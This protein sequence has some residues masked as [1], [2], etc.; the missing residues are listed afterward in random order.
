[1]P[2]STS[3]HFC[4]CV[5]SR[6]SSMSKRCFTIHS[7]GVLD[8][9][10]ATTEDVAPPPPP[11]PRNESCGC[12]LCPSVHVDIE[13][14]ILSTRLYGTKPTAV[15]GRF[16]W[17][18]YGRYHKNDRRRQSQPSITMAGR[19]RFRKSNGRVMNAFKTSGDG[20]DVDFDQH[21]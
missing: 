12:R 18:Q 19:K 7:N 5:N 1:M 21:F 4:S 11:P 8:W 2:I 9:V 13:D 3:V 16:H 10:K 17:I 20:Q 15:T 14:A 6:Y